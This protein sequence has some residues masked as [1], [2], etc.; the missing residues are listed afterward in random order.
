MNSNE[1]TIKVTAEDQ[2]SAKFKGVESAAKGLGA[3][4]GGPLKIGAAAAGAGI[5]ALG[6]FLA[7]SVREAMESQK[8]TAQLEAAL[9][10]TGEAAGLSKQQLLDMASGLQ[11]MTTFGDEAIIGAQNLLLTFTQI[12]GPQFQGATEAVLNMATAM[13]TDLNT[14]A[15][16]VGKALNDP[17]QGITALRRA[18]VQ[19]SDQQE[20]MVK[21]MMAVGDVAGAQ[22][23]ILGELSTQFGGSAAAAADTFGGR[24]Q[25]LKNSFGEIQESI[26]M[27][28]LPHLQ[29]LAESLST[30][31]TENK[32]DIDKMAQ[33]FAKFAAQAAK[34]AEAEIWPML[35]RAFEQLKQ[36]IEGIMDTGI[37]QW[38]ADHKI[39]LIAVTLAVAALAAAL[40]GPVVAIP[41][42]IAAGTLLLAHWDEIRN[43]IEQI[44]AD[45]EEKFPFLVTIIEGVFEMIRARVE[46]YINTVRSIIQIVTALI[47]GDWSA[48]WQ[49]VKDIANGFLALIK[50]DVE[51]GFGLIKAAVE[52]AL[53]AVAGVISG[54]WG[55]IQ[56]TIRNAINTIIG[57]I[58]T[59][60]RAI[61]DLGHVEIAGKTIFDAPDIPTVAPIG[62]GSSSGGG[63][64]YGGADLDRIG[65]AV[66][67]AIERAFG[68]V[69][70]NID[71]EPV[72]RLVTAQQGF[73]VDRLYR[74]G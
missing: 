50:T 18:G 54:I 48:A 43:K 29:K 28:L 72:G 19:L 39:A 42:I 66:E 57:Y 6:G 10:S 69:A 65:S 4:L 26:G 61:N 33:D 21:D 68:R 2:A 64:P 16:Q 17:V 30:F 52:G 13:G 74:A 44:V 31:L 51:V 41:A 27:A 70:V 5:V 59:L 46:F 23:I 67:Q 47:H 9:K 38:L 20:Q 40:I 14:A 24:M 62:G 71:G 32:E 37:L 7:S 25:Q 49:G 15:L 35:A 34:F 53:G 1:V 45:F 58:N 36:L 55:G 22:K 73:Y 56:T 11:S 60:I 12:K 3:T 63:R 8:V